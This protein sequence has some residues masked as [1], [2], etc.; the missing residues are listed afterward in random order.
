M[1]FS[2]NNRSIL[3]GMAGINI[4]FLL[5][6]GLSVM[7]ENT[8]L[9]SGPRAIP[10]NGIL[11]FNGQTFTGQADIQFTL[12]DDN[13]CELVED[14]DNVP[15]YA[16]RFAVNLG[17]VA[18]DIDPCVFDANAIYLQ[19][20]VR[21]GDSS[22]P[23]VALAGRQ[24][25]TPVPFSYWAAEGSNFR[26]DGNLQAD[27]ATVQGHLNAQ[28]ATVTNNLTAGSLRTDGTLTPSAGNVNRGITWGNDPFG[29]T[30]DTAW[31]QY[32]QDGAGED[33]ALQIGVA[34]DANDDL[35]FVQQ[36]ATQMRIE[37]G[38]VTVTNNLSA[39][40]ANVT[41]ALS[42]GSLSTGAITA[43]GATIQGS[44]HIN[45]ALG[46]GNI[47]VN[48]GVGQTA[49]I[50][51]VGRNTSQA[52]LNASARLS[53]GLP[54]HTGFEIAAGDPA[55][56]FDLLFFERRGNDNNPL[57]MRISE[58]GTLYPSQ[59]ISAPNVVA[60]SYMRM[61]T[62]ATPPHGCDGNHIGAMYVDTGGNPWGHAVCICV[63]QDDTQAYWT[64][65]DNFSDRNGCG[66]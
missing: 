26:I 49:S 28:S 23:H 10:Y 54:G 57:M 45:G 3:V 35:E 32:I 65:A 15:I 12:T 11:E 64:R 19:M 63:Q 8:E 31:I 29:G 5:A 33:A 38:N 59:G 60:T 24:R 9:D 39:S 47:V 13:G 1:Q 66:Y 44:A 51:I 37:N 27:T 2:Q 17:S 56:E 7:A 42:S 36:G 6:L 50:G 34:N 25:I 61:P 14:H 41:A 22:D 18:G 62:G 21:G 46:T 4:G 58:G 52:N 40:S 43:T 30:G 55:G 20:A 48:G 53:L 16:G